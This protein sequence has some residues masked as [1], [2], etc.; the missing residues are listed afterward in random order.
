M[1]TQAPARVAVVTSS[2]AAFNALLPDDVTLEQVVLAR[3]S[4]WG[5]PTTWPTPSASSPATVH[6]GSTERT[7]SSMAAGLHR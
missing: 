6:P 7:S 3:Q 4:R 2:E 5:T 1:S